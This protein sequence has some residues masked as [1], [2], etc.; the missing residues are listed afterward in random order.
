MVYKSMVHWRC[1]RLDVLER[2]ISR[3]MGSI[4]SFSWYSGVDVGGLPLFGN[5]RVLAE[6]D[7]CFLWIKLWT[8]GEDS[9]P[10]RLFFHSE[11][12]LFPFQTCIGRR[13]TAAPWYFDNYAPLPQQW[14]CADSSDQPIQHHRQANKRND[15]QAIRP[16]AKATSRRLRTIVW[17]TIVWLES[18]TQE[19]PGE[20]I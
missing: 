1:F 2:C 17:M 3:Y 10:L 7:T 8:V 16:P 20:Y 15:S 19:L 13:P 4:R 11:H 18:I 6:L 9:I 14:D 5:R 12:F